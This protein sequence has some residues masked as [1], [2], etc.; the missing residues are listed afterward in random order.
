MKTLFD[1]ESEVAKCDCER[2]ASRD[3]H[4]AE[5]HYATVYAHTVASLTDQGLLKVEQDCFLRN[6]G[7]TPNPSWIPPQIIWEPAPAT[8]EKML[9]LVKSLHEQFAIETRHH[10]PK[11]IL[12]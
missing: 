6:G 3:F 7:D 12:V 1:C 8:E 10:L 4:Y 5:P 11:E 2:G 9:E